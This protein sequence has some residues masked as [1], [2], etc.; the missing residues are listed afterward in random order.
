[1]E[2]GKLGL[3]FASYLSY[4]LPILCVLPEKKVI[5]KDEGTQGSTI[6]YGLLKLSRKLL[7]D[8][9]W[10]GAAVHPSR[11][12]AEISVIRRSSNI[13]GQHMYS[14]ARKK[15]LMT[16]SSFFI[17]FPLCTG[18]GSCKLRTTLGLLCQR[19]AGINVTEQVIYTGHWIDGNGYN[20]ATRE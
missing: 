3:K 6:Q 1:M 18:N 8:C 5:F 9:Y 19:S 10:D 4:Q 2:Y 7:V 16:S 13:M 11:L 12:K 14:G 15:S 20:C 17:S